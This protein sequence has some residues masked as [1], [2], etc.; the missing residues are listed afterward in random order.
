MK[1]VKLK[2]SPR[3]RTDVAFC[4]MPEVKHYYTYG[5]NVVALALYLAK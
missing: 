3:I 4:F 1:K 2:M 5:I